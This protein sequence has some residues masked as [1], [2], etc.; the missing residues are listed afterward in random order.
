MH[1]FQRLF[2]V[3]V[4]YYLTLLRADL[5]SAS[6]GGVDVALG[7]FICSSIL[8][9][10][11]QSWGFGGAWGCAGGPGPCSLHPFMLLGA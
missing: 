5:L 8:W 11:A 9:S 2:L 7:S 10:R 6:N 3:P 1:T 4:L